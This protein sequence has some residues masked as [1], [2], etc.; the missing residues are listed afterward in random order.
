M[1]Q[2]SLLIVTKTL[3]GKCYHSVL[4]VR[5]LRPRDEVTCW[6]I[7]GRVKN[8]AQSCLNLKLLSFLLPYTIIIYYEYF[9]LWRG[10]LRGP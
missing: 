2:T 10:K 9:V 3:Q 7:G 5:K 6:S 1:L 4:L 8:K